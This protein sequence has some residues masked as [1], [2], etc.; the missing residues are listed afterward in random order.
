M[1]CEGLTL[2][3]PYAS[4]IALGAKRFETRNWAPSHPRTIV[5]CAGKVV[6][7]ELNAILKQS[8]FREALA[9]LAMTTMFADGVCKREHLNFGKAVAIVDFKTA[10]DGPTVA[11]GL[12]GTP[13]EVELR[14]G[15]F[16]IRRKIWVLENI[17]RILD[18]FP[19]K[20]GQKL[21]PLEIPDDVK[22]VE[23]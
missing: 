10:M 23:V 19:V 12:R 21:F 16:G 2:H 13:R 4:L 5:I 9:P 8:P 6:I 3:E 18:P 14:F 7:K 1:K 22:T 15:D 17:R 20:G 11:R